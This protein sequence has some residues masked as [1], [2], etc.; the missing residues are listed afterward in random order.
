MLNY[1]RVYSMVG[2]KA[3]LDSRHWSKIEARHCRDGLG[4]WAGP[5]W[6]VLVIAWFSVN[7]SGNL[8]KSGNTWNKL[9]PKHSLCFP[10]PVSW[11]VLVASSAVRSGY[12]RRFAS[13]SRLFGSPWIHIR[14]MLKQCIWSY[15]TIPNGCENNN[16]FQIHHQITL[17]L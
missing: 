10:E 11:Q 3:R 7:S 15:Y 6:Q 17:S 2:F 16:T 9:F 5:F 8:V 4:L 13:I 12:S 1:Q 14:R